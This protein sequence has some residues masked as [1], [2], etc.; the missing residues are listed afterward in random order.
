[1]RG[2]HFHFQADIKAVEGLMHEI[3]QVQYVHSA[4][5]TV[6]SVSVRICDSETAGDLV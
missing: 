1:M 2:L 3:D 4:Q 6:Q 5:C